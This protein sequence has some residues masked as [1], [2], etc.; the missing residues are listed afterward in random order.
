MK[1]KTS[2]WNRFLCMFGHTWHYSG[3]KGS[4]GHHKEHDDCEFCV[5]CGEERR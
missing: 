2:L 3:P 1:K 4:H 5:R